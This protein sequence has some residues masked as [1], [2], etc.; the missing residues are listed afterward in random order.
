MTFRGLLYRV[1]KDFF[2]SSNIQSTENS[3][4]IVFSLLLVNNL[5]VNGD[6]EHKARFLPGVCSGEKIGGM[7]MS[8]PG[9]GTDVLGMKTKAIYDKEKNGWI[10]NGQ[11]VRTVGWFV[12]WRFGILQ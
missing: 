8:E 6:H 12:L 3:W 7:G 11:K 4:S 2:P 9:A 5:A 1:V 10:L